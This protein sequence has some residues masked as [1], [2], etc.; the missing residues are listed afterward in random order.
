M[1]H[2]A[3]QIKSNKDTLCHYSPLSSRPY[4]Q[5]NVTLASFSSSKSL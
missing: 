2:F 1:L 4:W 3:S 5:C